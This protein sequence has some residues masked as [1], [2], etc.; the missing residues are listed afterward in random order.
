MR[1]PAVNKSKM[2]TPPSKESNNAGRKSSSNSTVFELSGRLRKQ[3]EFNSAKPG[4]HE[5][6]SY[7]SLAGHRLQL[8]TG[9]NGP[10]GWNGDFLAGHGAG[11]RDA[12]PR[13]RAILC[14]FRCPY[15]RLI[16]MPLRSVTPRVPVHFHCSR[17]WFAP[18]QRIQCVR[19]IDS[20]SLQ[21]AQALSG[22]PFHQFGPA[23]QQFHQDR[24][25]VVAV[26]ASAHVPALLEPVN[27]FHG[28][29]VL[30][31]QP[32]RQRLDS[33]FRA[34]REA[35]DRKQ[36]KILLRFEPLPACRSIGVAQKNAYPI[37]QRGQRTVISGRDLR[38]HKII[39]S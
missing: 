11:G 37:T 28:A 2:A 38:C 22:Y 34:F 5:H 30:Q 27:Q 4:F 8:P 32:L 7:R 19:Q 16:S 39:I 12:R 6:A 15:S 33:G 24:S 13:C 17:F 26:L 29:V 1:H 36:Q 9:G 25:P 18:K 20:F 21:F 35:A 23:R 3:F 10:F 14:C 31:D